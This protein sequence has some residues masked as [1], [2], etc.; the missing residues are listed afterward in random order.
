MTQQ[1]AALVEQ[2]TAASESMRDQTARLAQAVAV[3]RLQAA[4]ARAADDRV[5]WCGVAEQ[6]SNVLHVQA[7]AA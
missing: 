4:H 2:V 3:F 7:A 6:G 1:N 5:P